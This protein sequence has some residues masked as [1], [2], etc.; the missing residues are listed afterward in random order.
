MAF[1]RKLENKGSAYSDI[2][3]IET[4]ACTQVSHEWITIITRTFTF[5]WKAMT[6]HQTQVKYFVIMFVL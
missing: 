2:E 1:F 5:F 3:T 6:K 4:F